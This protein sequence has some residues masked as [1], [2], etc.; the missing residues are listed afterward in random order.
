ME[1]G[2]STGHQGPHLHWICPLIMTLALHYKEQYL[3]AGWLDRIW[4]YFWHNRTVNLENTSLNISQPAHLISPNCWKR[5]GLW[6]DILFINHVCSIL[7]HSSNP[8]CGFSMMEQVRLCAAWPM[9]NWLGSSMTQ[10]Q[11]WMTV[12]ECCRHA[13]GKWCLNVQWLTST[14]HKFFLKSCVVQS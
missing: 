13:L 12:W 2:F 4:S 11:S 3:S 14:S 1:P 5:G 6:P 7:G 8:V 9:E 10:I